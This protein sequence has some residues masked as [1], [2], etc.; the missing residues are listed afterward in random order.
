MDATTTDTKDMRTR[1][2]EAIA[3]WNRAD[4]DEYMTLYDD[5]V[6]LYG[7]GPQPMDKTAVR[8]FYEGIFGGMPGSQIEL[9]DTFG[10][11]DRIA[12]RFV[13]R[14]RHDGDLMGVPATGREVEINGI[15]VLVFRDGG[16]IQRYASA[17]MLGLMVQ[18]GAIPAPA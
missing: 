14:G 9:L 12:A 4:L 13:Q 7:Y 8:G 10:E 16:V 11:G 1:L 15:T 18:L 5:G 6:T 2:E 17:D 3:A